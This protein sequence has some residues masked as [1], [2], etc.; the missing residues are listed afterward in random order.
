MNNGFSQRMRERIAAAPD[1]SVFTASDFADI[2]DTATIR[3]SL[4]RLVAEKVL[5]RVIRGVCEKPRYSP[6]L[7]ESVAVDPDKVAQAL[8]RS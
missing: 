8:A 2:A 6:R 1:G 3:Q 5:R 7:N 4:N